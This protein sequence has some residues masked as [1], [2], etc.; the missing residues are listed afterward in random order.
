MFAI[1]KLIFAT[2]MTVFAIALVAPEAQAGF[3]E[4]DRPS[5]LIISGETRCTKKNCIT[6]G[7]TSGHNNIGARWGYNGSGYKLYRDRLGHGLRTAPARKV[8]R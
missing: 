3:P 5:S 6:T 7:A 2:S 1:I 8:R 4:M